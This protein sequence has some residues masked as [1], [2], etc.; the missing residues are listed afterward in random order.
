MTFDVSTLKVGDICLN[1]RGEERKFMGVE[2]LSG[3]E[4]K[5]VFS[6][7]YGISFYYPNG[8]LLLD[9]NGLHDIVSK[10]EP[11]KGEDDVGRLF[12]VS[13]LVPGD[14]CFTRSG[15]KVCYLG[16]KDG[17]YEFSDGLASIL[18]E[19]DGRVLSDD[20]LHSMD[21]VSKAMTDG[22]NPKDIISKKEPEKEAD[23]EVER[24]AKALCRNQFDNQGD[25]DRSVDDPTANWYRAT[26]SNEQYVWQ[27][28]INAAKAAI[29]AM[30]KSTRPA[31]EPTPTNSY[32]EIHGA[33]INPT[34]DK[35]DC[36]KPEAEGFTAEQVS[37][38]TGIPRGQIEEAQADY[39]AWKANNKKP[40]KPQKYVEVW[41][42]AAKSRNTKD[43]WSDLEWIKVKLPL[44]GE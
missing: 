21:I 30:K 37:Q 28:H 29:A 15:L 40:D 10:K 39:E 18:V 25:S 44:A 19:S 3:R 7:Y 11:E 6:D 14:I 8:R 32:E 23:D 9:A 16:M 34:L 38:F 33:C 24:V 12:G 36:V 1:R 4:D 22:S 2:D 20:F 5:Y 41:I 27:L 17:K 31:F 26:S 42:R 35:P 13:T 43:F